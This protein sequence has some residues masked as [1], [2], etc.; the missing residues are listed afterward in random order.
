[1]EEA[2]PRR[3]Q[4]LTVV[5]LG[6]ILGPLDG[7]ILNVILPTITHSFSATMAVAEW[8]PM[9]Y[10]LTIAGLVL[11]FGRLG[12]IV[13]YRRVFLSGLVGF[14]AA[15]V[16]CATS[17][18][19][20]AL[21]AFRALQG[22]AASMMMAVP[23]A[24]L[25]RTFPARQRGQALG[26]YALSISVGLAVGPSLGGFLTSLVS[27]RAAFLINVPVGLVAFVVAVRVLP[28]MRGRAGRVDVAGAAL[29]LAALSSF[30]LFVTEAQQDGLTT[31]TVALL[32]IAVLAAFLFVRTERRSSD[33]MLPLHL[34]RNPSLSCGALASLF[35]FI[36]Q[37]VV[38]F[39]TPF[40][41]QR[42]LEE[43]PGRVGLVMTA[44]PVAVLCVAPASGALSDRIGTV[45]PAVFGMTVCALSCGLLATLPADAGAEQ[46]AWRLGL[47]GLGAGIFGSPNNSAVM[48]S[49]PREHLGVVSSLLGTVR[50]VGMVLG[51]AAGAAVL[52]ALV[53]ESLLRG[54]P[55]SPAQVATYL[56]GL[57]HAY[58]VGGCFALGA[59]LLSAARGWRRTRS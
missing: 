19:I 32:A 28:E 51:V 8:V 12:D 14:V 39:L 16:L 33:P 41:L 6:S 24:I 27:W 58:A 31:F 45:G 40:F 5:M 43:S 2:Y 55:L 38:V 49:A 9:V 29:A 11:L 26:L 42:V 47:F 4:I 23:L 1:M 15:S 53:P 36:G 34:F 52:Y 25:T 17:P 22:L 59:A 30:L 50:T 57:R 13:G 7:S 37:F 46:V 48:G 56:N 10:L 21:V 3:Y 54:G 20:H 18:T 35:N 44:F